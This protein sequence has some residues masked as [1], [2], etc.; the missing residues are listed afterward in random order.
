MRFL[1]FC[2]IG[3]GLI[4]QGI[5]NMFGKLLPW[6]HFEKYTE[7]SVQAWC[8]PNGVFTIIIG[9]GCV[10]GDV[11][12]WFAH[13]SIMWFVIGMGIA[14]VG[15]IGSLWTNKKYLVKR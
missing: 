7:K 12:S 13:A 3:I 2:I 10:F 11:W 14:I 6:Q 5:L 4:L 8:R 15:V 9:V 1:A